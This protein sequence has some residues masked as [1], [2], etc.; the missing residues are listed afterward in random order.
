MSA[1]QRAVGAR[2]PVELG[3]LVACL[4][5]VL[6]ACFMVWTI[7]TD[8]ATNTQSGRILSESMSDL[9]ADLARKPSKQEMELA[10][11]NAVL[12]GGATVSEELRRRVSAGE[13]K[14][15]SLEQRIKDEK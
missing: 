15:D 9:K 3:L 14:V 13:G 7:K 1:E 12:K 6:S 10:I 11:E 2:T 8:V 4:G 5:G